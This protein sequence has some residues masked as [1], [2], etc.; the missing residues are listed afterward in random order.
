[1]IRKALVS[2]SKDCIKLIYMSGKDMF[3]YF[4]I[5]K[6]PK[7]YDLIEMF[8]NKPDLLFSSQNVHVK[9]DN[10]KVCGMLLTI[11]AKNMK[12]LNSNTLKYVNELIQIGGFINLI[13]MLFRQRLERLINVFN[14]EDEYYISNI[15][16]FKEAQGKGYGVELLKRAEELAISEGYKK[17]SLAVEF[18]NTNA[19]RVY[20]KFGFKEVQTIEFPR[21]YHKFGLKGFYKMIKELN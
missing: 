11:P 20:E 1:M 18:Y 10:G 13:K 21:K 5:Q 2:E 14:V 16:V 4:L 9:V 17:L 12:Q 19:K 6:E 15:A 3:S 8:Y 7:I